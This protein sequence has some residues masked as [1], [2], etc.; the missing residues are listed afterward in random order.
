MPFVTNEGVRTH[1]GASAQLVPELIAFW[2][3]IDAS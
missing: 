3:A 1:Y 2:A